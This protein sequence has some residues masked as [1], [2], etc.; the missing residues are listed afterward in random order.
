[1]TPID[2]TTKSDNCCNGKRIEEVYI[3]TI[4]LENLILQQYKISNLTKICNKN[5]K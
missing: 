3:N 2:E 4:V 5:K 1:M